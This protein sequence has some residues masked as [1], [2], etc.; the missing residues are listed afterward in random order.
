MKRCIIKDN[1]L[2]QSFDIIDTQKF[3][4]KNDPD[5][6]KVIIGKIFSIF[7]AIYYLYYSLRIHGYYLY[8]LRYA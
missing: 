4:D 1:Y 5:K 2:T 3:L 8:A 7:T 6:H